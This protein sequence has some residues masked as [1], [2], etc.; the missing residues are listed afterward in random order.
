MRSGCPIYSSGCYYTSLEESLLPSFMNPNTSSA[1]RVLLPKEKRAAWSLSLI[2][3]VRMLGLFIILPVFSLFSNHYQYSTPFLIGLAI[4]IYGLLQA[5]FQIPFGMLSDRFGR[6]K[7]ITVGLSLMAIGSVMAAVSESI[8]W[9]IAGRALQ[10]TGAIASVLMAL[11]ADLTRGIR[12]TALIPGQ[13]LLP[14]RIYWE[15]HI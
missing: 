8:Y 10:G 5:I 14:L 3:I 1:D 4:G 2:Y 7:I 11:A 6:K 12:V 13:M 9:V 15:T